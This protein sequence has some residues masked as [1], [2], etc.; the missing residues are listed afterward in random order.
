MDPQV[1]QSLDV[2]SFSLCS[3]LC[4][5]N[6]FRREQFWV[7][8]LRSGSIPQPGSVPN[9]WILFSGFLSP[10]LGISANV[11]PVGSWE[12]LVFLSSGIFPIPHCY[13]PLFNFLYS[14][15]QTQTLL[16]MP[17][18]LLTGGAY[19]CLLRGSARALPIHM[20]ML[21]AS[22]RTEEGEANGGFR[23]GLKERTSRDCPTWGSIPYA[24][25]SLL[26]Y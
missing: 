16:L 21:A 25:T 1:G 26:Y 9:L 19:G 18:S 20:Q 17:R 5:C 13:T 6:S 14:S 10:L 2:L 23:G 15:H 7:K 8:I 22:H 3:T 12:S 11:I 24:A 4:P